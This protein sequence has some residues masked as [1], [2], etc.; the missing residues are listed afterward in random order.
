[1][2]YWTEKLKSFLG[3]LGMGKFVDHTGKTFTKWTV[4]KLSRNKSKDGRHL[5]LCRCECGTEK[6]VLTNSL[7]RGRS[8]SCGCIGNKTHGM[9]KS[10][11]YKSWQS[12]KERCYN[13]NNKRYDKYGGRGIKVCE[14]WLESFENFYEDIGDRP[15]KNHSLE[16]TDVNKDYCLENCTW[17]TYSTQNRN[18][19]KN[20]RNTSG[21]TGVA[22]CF[23]DG[24]VFSY[25]AIWVDLEG[26][27]KSKSFSINKYGKEEAF[28][29]ACEARENAIKELNEQGAGYSE[30]HG[31]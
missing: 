5:W 19:R 17:A 2:L 9:H 29:L 20:K 27:Q 30:N 18:R 8:K 16:R 7:T 1:M 31:K 25:K 12:M 21:C 22:Q 14:R 23:K 3:E 28:R 15:S 6:E 4:I 13:K 26:K 10:K 24:V 11:E